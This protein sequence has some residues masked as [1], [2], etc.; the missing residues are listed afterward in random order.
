MSVGS[1]AWWSWCV[2]RVWWNLG[3]EDAPEE[4]DGAHEN[5]SKGWEHVLGRGG[6]RAVRGGGL[7]S[8]GKLDFQ[9]G[10]D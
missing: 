2:W 10:W 7:R 3:G 9:T 4:Q 8:E 5:G 6:V 1:G